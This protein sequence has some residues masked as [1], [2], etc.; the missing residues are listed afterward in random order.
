MNHW[1]PAHFHFLYPH[2]L[3]L[4]LAL[5]I[6]IALAFWRQRST[7][8]ARLADAA[9]L[10]YLLVG[11]AGSR[12]A[13]ACLSALIW[14]LASLALAGPTWREIATPLLA[15]QPAQVLA[16][17]LAQTMYANDASPSRMDVAR[18]KASD[19]L[20]A[21]AAGKNGLVG[22]A[23]EAFAVLSEDVGHCVGDLGPRLTLAD[24]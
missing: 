11:K 23:G 8:F 13:P 10:P 14:L 5:P 15:Q 20:T 18:F 16:L 4:L 19:L 12:V 6:V 17:S 22:F 24:R 2:W 3:W 1:L 21:N 7:R 9:L